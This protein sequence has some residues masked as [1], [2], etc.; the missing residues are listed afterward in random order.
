MSTH[1][2]HHNALVKT[3][4]YFVGVS[5]KCDTPRPLQCV[6]QRVLH[7]VCTAV[8]QLQSAVFAAAD[9]NGQ[10]GVEDGERDVVGVPLHGLHAALAQVV[11]HLDTLVVA[12]CH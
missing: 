12:G 6:A 5:P 1:L 9:D 7:A 11:P 8:P 2:D 4:G 3:D 10:I